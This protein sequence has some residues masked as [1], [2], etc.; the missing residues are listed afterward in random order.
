MSDE[1]AD[2]DNYVAKEAKDVSLEPEVRLKSIGPICGVEPERIRADRMLGVGV[3]RRS[4]DDELL[5]MLEV[6]GGVSQ[7]AT[8]PLVPAARVVNE[9]GVVEASRFTSGE[10]AA[11]F[12]D[13]ENVRSGDG[14]EEN[15]GENC[16]GENTSAL[17]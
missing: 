13:G 1:E 7:V 5:V 9:E 6:G 16:P 15:A 14:G 11:L 3:D 8:V 12:G 17:S 4:V 10:T 2:K